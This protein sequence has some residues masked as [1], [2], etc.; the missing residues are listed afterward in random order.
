MALP[1][2][3]A[4]LFAG[5]GI[6]VNAS[7]DPTY[8]A[9]AL[10]TVLPTDPGAP[11]S[12]PVADIWVQIG[13]SDAVLSQAAAALDVAREDLAGQLELIPAPNSPVIAVQV[14]TTDPE[15]SAVRA[16]V[17]AEVLLEQDADERVPGY[18]LEQVT[19]AVIPIDGSN[20]VSP[21]LLNGAAL[22]GALTGLVAAQWLRRRRP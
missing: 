13:T 10:V 3:G 11:V 20:R 14:T 17:V 15:R 5:A 6:A 12:Q 2:L 4:L 1:L 16:D 21:L 18:R 22:L 7:T 8:A 19:D 9:E